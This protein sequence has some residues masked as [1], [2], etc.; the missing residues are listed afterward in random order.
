MKRCLVIS[1]SFKGTLSTLDIC[2]MA[3]G[4][5]LPDWQVDALPVA[6]GG[7][8]TVDCFLTGC[9]GTYIAATVSDPFGAK[10]E[11]GYGWLPDGTAVVECAAAA[12]L[13]LAAGRLDPLHTTTY[14]VG[15][16]MRCALENG[17][18]RLVLGLGGSCTNDGGCG[19]AAAL[20]AVFR[21]QAGRPFVPVGGTLGEIDTID[22]TGLHP[23]LREVPLTVMCDIDNPLYGENGAAFVF[24]PQK[25]ATSEQVSFLD[26]GLRR[27]AAVIR[28]DTGIDVD[29]LSGGGAAGGFG[30]GC[31][32]LLGGQLRSGIE[33]VL[34]VLDFD[35]RAA[36]YDLIVTGEGRLD[37]Q[38]LGGKVV[39]GVASRCRKIAVPV[40]ALVGAL[41]LEE[42]S[43]AELGLVCARS[44]NPPDISFEQAALCAADYYPAALTA[45]LEELYG[46][47]H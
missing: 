2:R 15:E 13:T 33:T 18:K 21:D 43:L 12:G 32:A 4:V 6:D 23:K 22:L 30:A 26:D 41:A 3:E 7:E 39:S 36:E 37:S 16:L 44:I 10:M 40:A 17:A 47:R 42:A 25:G 24:A 9:G 1:D 20:G 38:S 5:R 31:A 46:Q 8:G 19:A 29:E 28:R 14:G 27:L 35:R 11:S 45:L 34:D